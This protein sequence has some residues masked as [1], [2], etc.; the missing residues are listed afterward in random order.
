MRFRSI[1]TR[2]VVLVLISAVPG[3]IVIGLLGMKIG[4]YVRAQAEFE[5]E[6]MVHLLGH[7]N[8]TLIM[9]IEQVLS[10]LSHS[11]GIMHIPAATHL[12]K[13][14]QTEKSAY[15]NIY[16]VNSAG[17]IIASAL[18]IR[19]VDLSERK[20]FR[21]AMTKK[22]FSVGEFVLGATYGRPRLHFA[23][24]VL[25]SRGDAVGVLVAAIELDTYGELI[26]IA[27]LPEGSII[28]LTDHAGKRLYRYPDT[29]NYTGRQDL[30]SMMGHMSGPAA[31]GT[32]LETGVDGTKR[33]YAYRTFTLPAEDR[34]FL[35]MR[36]G[37]PVSQLNTVARREFIAGIGLLLASFLAI[38][39]IAWAF[40]RL[41][42]GKR[43]DIM[44]RASRKFGLGDFSKIDI[45]RV[46]DE[47]DELAVVLNSAAKQLEQRERENYEAKIAL[48]SSQETLQSVFDSIS[49]AIFIHRRDGSIIDVNDR[50]LAMYG[51][52]RAEAAGLSIVEDYSAPGISRDGLT[53]IW[54]R[55]LQGHAHHFEW[56]ARRPHD[57]SLFDVEVF[58]N[59]ITLNGEYCILATA[60]DITSRKQMEAALEK[61]RLL[62][63]SVINALP[64]PLFYKDRGGRYLWCN[65]AYEKAFGISREAVA[66]KTVFDVM[67]RD[68]A[69]INTTGDGVVFDTGEPYT[70]EVTIPYADGAR[71]N[72]MSHKAPFF[73]KNGE[74]EGLVGVIMDITDLKRS[75]DRLRDSLGE[76]EVLLKEIHHRVKNNLQIISS[77]LS[78]QSV[79]IKDGKM[80]EIFRDSQ[81]RVRTMAL[82]HQK[83]Y[84]SDDLSGIHF[85]EYAAELLRD[86]FRSYGVMANNMQYTIDSDET[87]LDIDTMVP[88]GLIISELI[89]NA[90]KHAFPGRGQG[91][92]F[93]G[94]RSGENG[95]VLTVADD[96]VGLPE[97]L[98][99]RNAESL[100]LKLV[101]TLVEQLEGDL[102]LANSNGTRVTMTMRGAWHE[103]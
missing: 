57:G 85:R 72:L 52:T 28:A 92:V 10:T 1:R 88:V 65:K 21:D 12:L 62:L 43:F 71:H 17:S 38:L 102:H 61:Q 97:G 37:V 11:P 25:N 80:L 79:H 16:V 5:L 60:R 49:D 8:E 89:S 13:K 40:S 63:E 29:Q 87:F 98:D 45:P 59:R 84:Q 39:V 73:G 18:P 6:R 44:R 7:E 58:L 46:G 75:E 94:F 68:V 78:L 77:L 86:L 54:K 66:G 14:V 9:G 47:L 64:A 76:K 20:Y 96:G 91:N 26:S 51:V 31:S 48:Q 95:T 42:I 15:A 4:E 93:V 24:P 50:M 19:K 101:M 23:Y 70:Y 100:G 81:S 27:K 32:F 36:V 69:E 30:G 35:Y 33:F 74:I 41:T 82:V 56:Q 53:A 55:V 99:I 22:K 2:I 103:E 3:L 34:P 67:P 83:L 90:I